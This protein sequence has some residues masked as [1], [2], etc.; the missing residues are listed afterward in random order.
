MI[1]ED[2]LVVVHHHEVAVLV[3]FA[4]CH[5]FGIL[6]FYRSGCSVSRVCESLLSKIGAFCVDGVETAVRHD[7][8]TAHFEEIRI[9]AFE[10]QWNRTN[11]FYVCSDIVALRSV[12]T[13]YSLD[14]QSVF[15]GET[16]GNAVELQLAYKFDFFFD[17]FLYASD[18][19]LNFFNIIGV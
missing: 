14:E 6:K 2:H 11:R 18:E 15:V 16:Y 3:E 13:S 12:A 19:I 5:F 17:G 7:Y 4:S 9:V 8:F 1:L 10:T